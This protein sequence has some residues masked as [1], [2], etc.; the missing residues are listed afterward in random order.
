LT[1]SSWTVSL[2]HQSNLLLVNRLT[3]TN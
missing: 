3:Y 2:S 1:D